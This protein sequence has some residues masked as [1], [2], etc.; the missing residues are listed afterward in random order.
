MSKIKT[1][2]NINSREVFYIQ[3]CTNE[4]KH[5]DKYSFIATISTIP[6]NETI[7]IMSQNI[8]CKNQNKNWNETKY[9]D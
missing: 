8:N 6:Q 5:H 9:N 7:E 4:A 2:V 1:I 3:N